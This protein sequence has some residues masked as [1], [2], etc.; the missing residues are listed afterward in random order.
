MKELELHKK[1]IEEPLNLYMKAR[2]QRLKSLLCSVD[3][4]EDVEDSDV[5]IVYT[6]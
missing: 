5:S 1:V 2:K 4:R 6:L 3:D